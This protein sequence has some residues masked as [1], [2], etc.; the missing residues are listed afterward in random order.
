MT[1]LR[2]VYLVLLVA[3]IIIVSNFGG[4]IT[5]AFFYFMLFL[6]AISFFYT[7][8]VY[9]RFKIYQNLGK[10][11]VVKGEKN[12]Y[13][14]V[15]ANE[16]FITYQNIKI[17][18]CDKESSIDAAQNIVDYHLIPK[19]K[20]GAT[21]NIICNFRGEYPVGIH[22]V[23]VSDL[24]GLFTITYPVRSKLIA[25]V[26]PRLLNLNKL[27]IAPKEND[28]KNIVLMNS[29]G[30]EY[31]DTDVR[32]YHAGDARRL[33]HHKLSARKGELMTRMVRNMPEESVRI[34]INLNQH[35]E[36]DR[37][38]YEDKALEA[39][40]AIAQFYL[41][42]NASSC[43]LFET[44]QPE[45]HHIFNKESFQAFYECCSTLT[46]HAKGSVFDLY[47]RDTQTLTAPCFQV[48]ITDRL[49]KKSLEI[50]RAG[51]GLG[52]DIVVLYIKNQLDKEEETLLQAYTHLN[53][54]LLQIKNDDLLEDMI[55]S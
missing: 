7:L 26:F 9:K 40:L 11:T 36:D 25:T 51:G 18:F 13:T 21:T 47:Q 49:E 23:Q 53:I 15:L 22:S 31:L 32:K 24:I 50:L 2:I 14:Y 27:S 19:D 10:K 33:I 30:K 5:Y 1:K 43:V 44:N 6:P 41:R 37:I 38:I 48:V 12:D 34:Y 52:N 29:Y 35:K 45:L 39:A 28:S 4:N 17:I 42:K 55:G 20:I 8:Y 46:F 54:R 16:D 3:S